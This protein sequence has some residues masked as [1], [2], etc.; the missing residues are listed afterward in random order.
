MLMCKLGLSNPRNLGAGE[1]DFDPGTTFEPLVPL[2][3]LLPFL[4][5]IILF[6]RQ[7][8][9]ERACFIEG[10]HPL[11]YSRDIQSWWGPSQVPKAAKH[12]R[13]EN[14][15]VGESPLPPMLCTDKKLE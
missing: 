13:C 8:A 2:D 7:I 3:S 11:A 6:E 14:Q 12:G 10:Y 5:F 1:A 15:L 4:F 9:R